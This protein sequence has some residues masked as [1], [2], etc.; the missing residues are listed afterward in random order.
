MSFTDQVQKTTS[1]VYNYFTSGFSL[2]SSGQQLQRCINRKDGSYKIIANVDL[3]F[4]DDEDNCDKLHL[5]HND[6]VIVEDYIIKVY[7]AKKK[8]L[9]EIDEETLILTKSNDLFF[10]DQY[11]DKLIYFSQIRSNLHRY[12]MIRN[13]YLFKLRKKQEI[14]AKEQYLKRIRKKL[15]EANT[16]ADYLKQ[17]EKTNALNYFSNYVAT[18]HY[19]PIVFSMM[20]T[21][22]TY[23]V[24]VVA[25]AAAIGVLITGGL[26]FAIMAAIAAPIASGIA[27]A[28]SLFNAIKNRNK[29][30]GYAAGS[31]AC[32]AVGF[33]LIAL[34]VVFPLASPILAPIGTFLAGIGVV[35]TIMVYGVKYKDTIKKYYKKARRWLTNSFIPALKKITPAQHFKNAACLG[36]VAIPVL[37]VAAIVCAFVFPPAVPFLLGAGTLA[38]IGSV[39]AL[40]VSKLIKHKQKIVNTFNKVRNFVKAIPKKCKSFV[41]K[42]KSRFKGWSIRS[43]FKKKMQKVTMNTMKVRKQKQKQNL[44]PTKTSKIKSLMYNGVVTSMIS[45]PTLSLYFHHHLHHQAL[46]AVA[47]FAVTSIFVGIFSKAKKLFWGK[48]QRMQIKTKMENKTK[49]D[50]ELIKSV[51]IDQQ[52]NNGVNDKV[53]DGVDG[54]LIQLAP[55]KA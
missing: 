22:L 34:A 45:C 53:N 17:L 21:I 7:D 13:Y 5:K 29:L 9:A 32:S 36:A 3:H 12:N 39:G 8:Q 25:T 33:L 35:G 11:E 49:P 41:D 50:V 10:Y 38:T 18:S 48:K 31:Y 27:A 2:M 52:G 4:V 54:D 30:S 46:H 1:L 6:I 24:A 37:S 20:T 47:I 44:P 51:K 55:K 14:K 19:S 26:S 28:T 16:D 15:I 43:L 40:A 23:I 42:I